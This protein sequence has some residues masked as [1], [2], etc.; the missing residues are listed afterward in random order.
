MDIPSISPGAG[1]A[2]LGAIGAGNE[3]AA[4]NL[5]NHMQQL[6]NKMYVPKTN[7]AINALV[8]ETALNK[9]K[10]ENPIYQ[11]P[12]AY[13]Y[14]NALNQGQNNQPNPNQNNI[15][16]LNGG[17]P[18][19]QEDNSNPSP[20]INSLIQQKIDPLAY[21][22]REAQALANVE[23]GNKLSSEANQSA[24]H[25]NSMNEAVKLMDS[26]RKN[27]NILEKS[28]VVGK[29]HAFSTA[30]QNFDR[31]A[32]TFGGN[33]LKQLQ[34]SGHITDRDVNY[35]GKITPT[36]ESTDSAFK[37]FSNYTKELTKRINERPGFY[38]L[39]RKMGLTPQQYEP[40]WLKYMNERPVYDYD[41]DKPIPGNLGSYKEYLTPQAIQA[42]MNGEPYSPRLN[43]SENENKPSNNVTNEQVKNAVKKE[44]ENYK[45]ETIEMIGPKGSK[46][47]GKR[48][49]VPVGRAQVALSE[50]WKRA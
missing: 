36:R 42:T 2:M 17:M 32:T 28:P 22:T 4:Q 16:P 31:G 33:Q 30:A 15:N 14:S 25:A 39:A 43:V 50:G 48:Y 37:T 8:T 27:L 21:K 9:F 49:T 10:L 13:L 7:A 46:W 40:L 5:K 34:S 18:G 6:E 35:F 44:G 24:D 20:N 3:I 12:E 11:N 1:G 26:S 29:G 38:Q 41:K 47:E 45:S 19:G 23:L